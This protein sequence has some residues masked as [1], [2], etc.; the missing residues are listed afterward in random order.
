MSRRCARALLVR[1]GVRGGVSHFA[2]ERAQFFVPVR[3]VRRE[4]VPYDQHSAERDEKDDIARA[5]VEP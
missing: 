4:Q 1:I 5:L 3:R 2:L